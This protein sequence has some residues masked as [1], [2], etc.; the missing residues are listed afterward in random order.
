M[1]GNLFK[2]IG[3]MATTVAMVASLGV[4]AFAAND[5]T[6]DAAGTSGIIVGTPV[7]GKDGIYKITIPYTA[8]GT[9]DIGVTMLAYGTQDYSDLAKDNAYNSESMRIIG[10]EQINKAEMASNTSFEFYV[11]TTPSDAA[12]GTY[13]DGAYKMKKGQKGVVLLSGDG[14]NGATGYLYMAAKKDGKAYLKGLGVN[15]ELTADSDPIDTITKDKFGDIDNA[16]KELIKEKV[17]LSADSTDTIKTITA[18]AVKTGTTAYDPANRAAQTVTYTVTASND[19]TNDT[20]FDVK[21]TF[22]ANPFVVGG[23]T[24]ATLAAVNVGDTSINAVEALTAAVKSELV[25]EVITFTNG[26]GQNATTATYTIADGDIADT[27]MTVSTEETSVTSGGTYRYTLTI[28][29]NYSGLTATQITNDSI[30]TVNFNVT[31]KAPW[32]VTDKEV[33]NGD[34]LVTAAIP[35]TVQLEGD[36]TKATKARVITAVNTALANVT[37]TAKGKDGETDVTSTTTKS[38]DTAWTVDG[39]V[40][41]DNYVAGTYTVKVPY[42]VSGA[43]VDTSNKLFVEVAVTVKEEVTVGLLGDVNYKGTGGLYADGKYGDN[44]LNTQDSMALLRAIANWEDYKGIKS[45]ESAD[46]NE[47]GAVNSKDS[48]ILLRFMA[49]WT[50]VKAEYTHIGTTNR[51]PKK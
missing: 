5:V 19:V 35:A 44:K 25:G 28:P 11:D 17:L 31:I 30:I 2:R 12:A 36:A 9:Y 29:A 45:L 13:T 38:N 6:T 39:S 48:M 23:D 34:A 1:K 20:T 32:T 46:V 50:D 33:R 43:A 21:V 8:D 40:L 16:V 22:E 26:S 7:A 18:C 41:A 15:S 10:V 14:A 4:T 49:N 24:T 42:T 3:A 37:V 47:D 27:M 51:N